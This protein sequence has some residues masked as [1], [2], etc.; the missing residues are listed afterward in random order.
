MSRKHNEGHGIDD[1]RRAS[2]TLPSSPSPE[3]RRR[4]PPPPS[5]LHS[6]QASK[7][8]SFSVVHSPKF[9]DF[10][11]PWLPPNFHAPS[12]HSF[13]L[14]VSF[15]FF[16][17]ANLVLSPISRREFGVIDGLMLLWVSAAVVND[18]TCYSEGFEEDKIR[19]WIPSP[20]HCC[21]NPVVTISRSPP[22]LTS[23]HL[24]AYPSLPPAPARLE[25]FCVKWM[26]RETALFMAT[27]S[28]ATSTGSELFRRSLRA[29]P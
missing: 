15:F 11:L 29:S 13:F 19:R 4:H 27:P 12:P 6:K 20:C 10:I 5:P 14:G 1:R 7:Q 18:L 3:T 25:N 9:P 8:Q 16:F 26:A 22:P 21:P 23:S 17:L 2:L 28:R 24:L